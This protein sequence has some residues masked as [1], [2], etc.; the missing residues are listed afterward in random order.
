MLES[1]MNDTFIPFHRP[2]IGEEEINEVTDTL[3]SGWLTTGPRTARF[4][5]E[6]GAHI[7]APCAVAV[8]SATAALHLALAGLEIGPGD[9]V[10]TTPMTFC[11]TV[12][13]I[14]HT[15]AT[16]V[17]ADIRPDGNIDPDEIRKRIT[18]RTRAIIP[19]HIA[20]LP[21]DMSAIWRLAREHNLRVIEDA[22]HAVGAYY[23]NQPIGAEPPGSGSD[24][25]AF[26]FYATKNL[27]TGEGG[28]LTTHRPE[29][30]ET[31]RRLSLHGTS[32]D[33]WDRYTEH[34]DWYYEVLAHGFKYN[35][36]DIQAAIGIHQL[37]K[38]EQFIERR[39]ALAAIYNRAFAPL[40]EVDL[41]PHSP[42][43]RH[44]WHL[45]VLRLN[46][47]Q[48]TIGRDEF[49]RELRKRGVGASVHFIPIPLH[50]FFAT[51]PLA[52]HAC[53]RALQLYQRIVSLP[54]YPALTEDQ[55]HYVAQ[56][57]CEIL[58]TSR[59]TRFVRSGIPAIP[60]PSRC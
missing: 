32:H 34:G 33:A 1:K 2:S 14:L 10:I 31:A 55:V 5:R 25:V 27:T 13:A 15:G 60:I 29:L 49:V 59:R 7:G 28:M 42:G 56:S 38:L 43:S 37:R 20:G 23:E 35:L 39:T 11:A 6:F 24:A 54:L 17:L 51:L 21:C 36:S 9:E 12:Q 16:P 30:A 19:V 3:R 47:P 44:A 50:P 4:E 46:L 48:L 26:S 52:Q 8:N 22:A 45:Y 40:E 57:V 18:S 58:E 53:P 41:P